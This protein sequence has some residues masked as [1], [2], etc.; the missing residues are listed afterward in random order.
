VTD[1]SH[2]VR[3]RT[4]LESLWGVPV[5]GGLP[6]LPRLRDELSALPAGSSLP[7]PLAHEL[8]DQF[9]A[10]TPLERVRRLAQR[11]ALPQVAS[12]VFRPPRQPATVRVAIAHDAAFH[13][14]FPDTLDLLELRGA[15]IATFSPLRDDDLPAETDIVYLGCGHPER[16][17]GELAANHC[18]AT[19]LRNHLCAGR[20]IYAEGGG[21]AYLCA[22]IETAEGCRHAM[23]G[24]LPATA[25]LD[26]HAWPPEPV[27]VTLSADNWLGAA[28]S[29]LR[30]YRSR[31]WHIRP[32]PELKLL[33]PRASC[34]C[35]LVGRHHAIG[36]T[37]HVN[38]A[39]QPHALS[40][41][42]RPHAASLE[43]TACRS[44]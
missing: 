12:R 43:L 38:F 30:G 7:T 28:G 3:L 11:R 10:L 13:C 41:F 2:L 1:E 37:L 16:F 24:A 18:M 42:L 33:C 19:A 36:S 8:G 44:R 25:V 15:T 21:L 4:V 26:A 5:L 32:S 29:R 14:Y 20:R 40:G 35:D 6:L 23:A 9:R 34:T 31:Q 27:Q 22:E 17:A 39:A